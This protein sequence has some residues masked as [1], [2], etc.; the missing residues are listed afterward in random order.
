[1]ERQPCHSKLAAPPASPLDLGLFLLRQTASRGSGIGGVGQVPY[2]PT[3]SISWD[4]SPP[5][6]HISGQANAAKLLPSLTC[7]GP[8][9]KACGYYAPKHTFHRGVEMDLDP[10]QNRYND[11]SV[12]RTAAE[13][14]SFTFLGTPPQPFSTSK[15]PL[16]AYFIQGMDPVRPQISLRKH[17][18]LANTIQ[19]LNSTS[20]SRL[21]ATRS[22]SMSIS[23]TL[24]SSTT[25][26]TWSSV[27]FL[28]G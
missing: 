5:S 1:M 9:D 22:S 8:S 25:T 10:H 6:R 26:C 2:H 24:A 28:C 4:V 14:L 27:D 19:S 13:Y 12:S 21:A 16:L 20:A 18:Q 11:F 15:S 17:S 23:N 3:L 7:E